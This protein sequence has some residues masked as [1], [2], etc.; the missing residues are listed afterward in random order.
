M[1]APTK[2]TESRIRNDGRQRWDFAFQRKL[3]LTDSTRLNNPLSDFFLG[4]TLFYTLV[5]FKTLFKRCGRFHKDI[6]ELII[7]D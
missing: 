2:T 3:E 7:I 4:V 5:F 1:Y 6:F